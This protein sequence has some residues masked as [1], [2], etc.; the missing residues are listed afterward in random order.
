MVSVC[1][2]SPKEKTA[3]SLMFITS[4]SVFSFLYEALNTRFNTFS[5]KIDAGWFYFQIE[6]TLGWNILQVKHYFD[7]GVIF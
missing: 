1:T 3:L 6:D 2:M 4:K 5:L 7:Y